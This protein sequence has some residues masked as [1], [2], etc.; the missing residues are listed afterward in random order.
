M[1]KA[2]QCARIP[3]YFGDVEIDAEWLERLDELLAALHGDLC[4][5]R[6]NLAELPAIT[7]MELDDMKRGLDE[8]YTMFERANR[9]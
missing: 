3:T 7:E 8:V 2:T 4:S 1:A 9:G 6:H 5:A